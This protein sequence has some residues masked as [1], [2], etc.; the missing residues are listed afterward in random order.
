MKNVFLNKMFTIV[1]FPKPIGYANGSLK[2]E[3]TYSCNE[4]GAMRDRG[5]PGPWTTA[6]F[7]AHSAKI[8][9]AEVIISGDL[10]GLYYRGGKWEEKRLG[11]KIAFVIPVKDV[12]KID[13]PQI[14]HW[15]QMLFV[16]HDDLVK[17][18]PDYWRAFLEHGPD[19]DDP[20]WPRRSPLAKKI[21]FPKTRNI[22]P[23]FPA[24]TYGLKASGLIQFYLDSS[25]RIVKAQILK[26]IG[27]GVEEAEIE[28]FQNS[29]AEPAMLDGVPVA[30]T[31]K[32]EI[33]FDLHN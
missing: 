23:D 3:V 6:N 16:E 2:G 25:G 4:D 30:T 5:A 11:Q 28:A 24:F 22:E 27:L 8:K 18:V 15:R 10:I 17:V 1:G 33:N 26:P 21:I 32:L 31:F 20:Q 12:S 9:K 29:V 13:E 19:Y 7:R 14:Q